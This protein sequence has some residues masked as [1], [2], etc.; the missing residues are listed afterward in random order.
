MMGQQDRMNSAVKPSGPGAL[1]D[2]KRL[3]ACKTSSLL[4]GASRSSRFEGCMSCKRSMV[5]SRVTSVPSRPSK[6]AKV[7]AAMS[8]GSESVTLS[9]ARQ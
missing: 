4:K 8:R 2:G 9:T 1:R 6:C 3:I 7:V 5:Q